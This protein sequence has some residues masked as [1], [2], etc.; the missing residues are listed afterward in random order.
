MPE[1][2]NPGTERWLEATSA[3]DRVRSVAFALQR[4]RTAGQIAE[5]AHV[6]EKT[7]RDHLKRLVEMDVLLAETGDGPTT[8]YP[9]PAFMRYREIRTLAREHDRDEL[10]EIVATLK[11]DIEAWREEF[12]VET[13][14]ELRASVADADVSVEAV[15]ERQKIAEDWAYTEY[16]LELIREALAQYDRLTARPPATA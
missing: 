11:S 15:Y 10:T 6:A 1:D 2:S 7:A 16:R 14:D 13:P 4:P 12:D 5:S 8:Y 9:D 3:F